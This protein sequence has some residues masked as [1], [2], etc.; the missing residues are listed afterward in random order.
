[1][2]RHCHLI[3]RTHT[4]TYL[5]SSFNLT[6]FINTIAYVDVHKVLLYKMVATQLS[7]N[8]DII[9]DSAGYEVLADDAIR[10]NW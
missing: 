6:S 8:C 5:L 3:M 9:T 1:M 7:L 4:L 10:F 2:E